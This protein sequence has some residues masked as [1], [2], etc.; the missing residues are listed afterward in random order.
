[1][2]ETAPT[3]VHPALAASRRSMA[4]VEAGDREGWLDL[5][6]PDALVEDP[7]GVSMFDPVGDGHRGRDA[8]GAFF[9]TAIAPN[10]VRFSIERSHAAGDEVANVGTITTTLGDGTRVLVDG[11]F[12]YRVDGDGRLVALRAYWSESDLRVDPTS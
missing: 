12:T 1:V 7:I 9:D 11:V 3:D 4:A 5:F 8:I 10:Q 6:A 2:T